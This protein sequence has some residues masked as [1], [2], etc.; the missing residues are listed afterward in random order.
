[1]SGSHLSKTKG[2]QCFKDDKASCMGVEQKDR[3][4]LFLYFFSK[5]FT[6]LK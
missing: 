6:F 2:L 4:I 3:K 5:N 1:V